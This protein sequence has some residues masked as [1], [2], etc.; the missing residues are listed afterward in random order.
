MGPTVYIL[1]SKENL[2][3]IEITF[4]LLFTR[5]RS[6]S[7]RLV[8]QRM[9]S[10]GMRPVCALRPWERDR[11]LRLYGAAQGPPAMRVAMLP[12]GCS[13]DELIDDGDMD[14]PALARARVASSQTCGM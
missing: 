11:I 10:A 6:Q 7:A 5:T 8:N 12:M 1:N 4:C 9:G 2:N 13:G 14:P 3:E